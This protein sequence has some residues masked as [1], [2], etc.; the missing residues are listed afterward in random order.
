MRGVTVS[1]AGGVFTDRVRAGSSLH[2]EAAIYGVAMV[3]GALLQNSHPWMGYSPRDALAR[4]KAG[5]IRQLKNWRA[6]K[7]T[8][9]YMISKGSQ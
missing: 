6:L 7:D 4:R 5:V 9:S 1:Y 8:S 3:A 2:Y